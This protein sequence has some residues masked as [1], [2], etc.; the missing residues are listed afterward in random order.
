MEQKIIEKE[1]QLYE[2]KSLSLEAEL[3][4]ERNARKSVEQELA[5]LNFEKIDTE[6]EL[7]SRI[8]KLLANKS[9]LVEDLESLRSERTSLSE[10]VR[11]LKNEAIGSDTS[12]AELE[13]LRDTI[14]KLRRDAKQGSEAKFMVEALTAEKAK[15]S[16]LIASLSR[17]KDLAA[18]YEI[19]CSAAEN[20]S[21]APAVLNASSSHLLHQR[22]KAHR[23]E[24]ATLNAKVSNL[25][26]Q[27]ASLRRENTSHTRNVARLITNL[28]SRESEIARIKNLLTIVEVER[29]GLHTILQTIQGSLRRDS[30]AN[31]QDDSVKKQLALATVSVNKYKDASRRASDALTKRDEEVVS[32]K[33]R[34]SAVTESEAPD[35]DGEQTAGLRS[36]LVEAVKAAAEEKSE[37]EKAEEKLRALGREMSNLAEEL[38]QL[39]RVKQGVK[40]LH[41]KDNPYTEARLA[42]SQ[43][44]GQKRRRVDGEYDSGVDESLQQ[45]ISELEKKEKLADRYKAIAKRKI[46]ELRIACYSIFGWDIRVHGANYTVASMYAE[47]EQEK[48]VFTDNGRGVMSLIEN[49]Y[50]QAIKPKIDQYLGQCHSI[51]ALLA[52]ITFENFEKTTLM[53]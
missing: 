40:V 20:P 13:S 43:G 39:G 41:V 52:E 14:S 15:V 34:L 49:E 4:E 11:R 48:L 44:V 45:R 21:S 3:E 2:A 16:E 27:L 31:S 1:K 24:M 47:K 33:A 51:P 30:T 46:E 8:S 7:R 42:H 38:E 22:A 17:D 28:N 10:A 37:R 18:G 5:N 50:C 25:K 26:S 35:I 32:L 53:P 12:K 23:Q 36:R 6:Q 29:S 19:L 9:G